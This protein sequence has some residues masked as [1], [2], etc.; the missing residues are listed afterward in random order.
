MVLGM[1]LLVVALVAQDPAAVAG[2]EQQFALQMVGRLHELADAFAA[3][4]QHG[5][6]YAL[7]KE[8]LLDYAPD[9]AKARD[10][11]GFT[12][13]GDLWR[14]DAA[15]VVIEKDLTG[16]K[17][18]LGK[19]EQQLLAL[20]KLQ[21]TEHRALAQAWQAAGDGARAALHWRRV[22]AL[23][24]GDQ[25]AAQ[26]LATQR[27]FGFVGTPDELAMVRR[28]W[29]IRGAVDWLRR[30]DVP[31]APATGEEPLLAKAELAHRGVR[32]EHFAVWGTLPEAQLRAVAQY[33]ERTWLLCQT[34]A[35]TYAGEPFVP[36]R[37]RDLVF[38]HSDAEYHR[39]LDLC[40]DQFDAG[41]LQFLKNDVDMAFVKSNGTEIR[42]VKTNGG[43][44]EA[45]DQAVRGVA[46]DAFFARTDGLWEGVGHA[47]CGFFFGRTLTFLLEQQDQKTVASYTQQLLLPDMAVWQKIAEQSAWAKSDS[48]TS[49]LVLISAARFSTEQ[50]VK[51]WAICDYLW[52]WQPQWLLELDRCRSEEVRTPPDVEREFLRRT[53]F[54]LPKLD[55]DWREFWAKKSALRQV[56]AADPLGDEK[57]KERP[58]RSAA[59]T[60]VDAV[61][62]A[63]VAALRGPL[64]FQHAE[65]AAT[66]AAL[67]Y[68]AQLAKALALREKREKQKKPVADVPL[69]VPPAGLGV[70][71]LWSPLE[72][73]A[74][75]ATWLAQPVWR[76]R[77]LHPGQQLFGA[78]R[79][80]H[81][82]V[83]AFGE[84]A[85]PM[86]RGAPLPWPRDG[87]HDVPGSAAATAVGE[88][89]A[90]AL[91]AARPD[92]GAEVGMPLS[93]HFVR[94][95]PAD[96]LARIVCRVH[97]DDRRVDGVLVVAQAGGADV[98]DVADVAAPAESA[99]GLV[100]FAP[101]APLPAG[102][103]LE[104]SWELP[105]AL[106]SPDAPPLRVRCTVKTP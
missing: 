77:L 99:P 7:R 67:A 53:G 58:A 30:W 18:V 10:K 84:P 106:G 17:K 20:R 1:V 42:F 57:A 16:D 21:L 54:E 55:H 98:A 15:K 66:G 23:A 5:R 47:V 3:Q 59:L 104:V 32:S 26:A 72:P 71:V 96:Q 49:E 86:Q 51:A 85:L 80:G 60:V 92:L 69:P 90:A 2:K 31:V 33:A 102:A 74:A 61:N 65:D 44:S 52:H 78:N 19:L 73:A 36:E 68:G 62:A 94:Q 29:Q 9:D 97:A 12:K 34:L 105:A 75:V 38:V 79:D 82:C 50:R 88:R 89:V 40:A 41:R 48:R 27:F 83:L 4:K 81:G 63:R 13:V 6:A 87:Q 8:L 22:L 39:V 35:G 28:A 25:A 11:C 103:Q 76:D 95:V 46:Q 93:L 101:F 70:D 24:P 91:R 37:R 100:V 45:L 64:G 56:M 14:A 43:E